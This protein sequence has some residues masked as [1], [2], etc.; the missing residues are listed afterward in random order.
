M[1]G[2]G[3]GTPFGGAGRPAVSLPPPRQSYTWTPEADGEERSFSVPST[4]GPG[5]RAGS[6]RVTNDSRGRI[7]VAL[8]AGRRP[9]DAPDAIVSAY[10]TSTI[11]LDAD[12]ITCRWDGVIGTAGGDAQTITVEIVAEPAAPTS[13]SLV[14]PTFPYS[15]V[16]IWT[17]LASGGDFIWFGGFRSSGGFR[18]DSAP[19]TD[20]QPLV[21]AVVQNRTSFTIVLRRGGAGGALVGVAEPLT[22]STFLVGDAGLYAE[23][24]KTGYGD[25]GAVVS[26]AALDAVPRLDPAASYPL[27]GMAAPGNVADQLLAV[28]DYSGASG[29]FFDILEIPEGR[30]AVIDYASIYGY[31]TLD[32]AIPLNTFDCFIGF[33]KGANGRGGGVTHFLKDS[34]VAD[35]GLPAGDRAGAVGGRIAAVFTGRLMVQA[36]APF[37]SNFIRAWSTNGGGVRVWDVHW[38]VHGWFLPQY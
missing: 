23:T 36:P 26:V 20:G 13:S 15:E 11:S 12:G 25:G 27:A 38:S 18:S 19:V 34:A 3:Q 8:G 6:V 30:T 10:S 29:A 24:F 31:V 7:A 2:F 1:T 17:P 14:E 33:T 37:G 16:A 22:E 28:G 32:P 4:W 9:A 5:A 35:Y 21:A